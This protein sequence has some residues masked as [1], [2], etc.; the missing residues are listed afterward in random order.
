M[1]HKDTKTTETNLGV[2][3]GLNQLTF[4]VIGAALEVHEQLGPGYLESL[5]ERAL[6]V[7]MAARGIRFETQVAFEVA[8]KSRPIGQGRL[9]FLV[10]RRLIVELK[11]V[12]ALLPIHTAQ[13]VAY[14]KAHSLQLA[15]LFNFNVPLLP[16][17]MKRV[18]RS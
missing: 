10:E 14:L 8:Y 11:A 3:E 1:E 18:I 6:A 7:E 2:D 16:Q 13:V 4:A 12:D 15:L 17:G 5:Y 9:D